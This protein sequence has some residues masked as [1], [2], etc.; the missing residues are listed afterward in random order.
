M[1]TFISHFG[2]GKRRIHTLKKKLCSN[3]QILYSKRG[4]SRQ[5][6]LYKK[7]GE[8]IQQDIQSYNADESHYSRQKCHNI[9]YLDSALNIKRMLDAFNSKGKMKSTYWYY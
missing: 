4:G 8:Y 5:N 1:K 7:L 3:K 9:K 2:V 6:I